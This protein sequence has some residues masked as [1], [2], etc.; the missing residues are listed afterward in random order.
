[1]VK[2]NWKNPDKGIWEF[3]NEDQHFTFS[4]VLC[5]VAIDRAIKYK[6]WPAIKALEEVLSEYLFSVEADLQVLEPI[7][8]ILAIFLQLLQMF[9]RFPC[10]IT[11]GSGDA[12]C[13]IDGTILAGILGGKLAP[14]GS[15]APDIALPVA[16][17]I[18]VESLPF[19][20]IE[21]EPYGGIGDNEVGGTDVIDTVDNEGQ[22]LIK[23]TF[24]GSI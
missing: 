15:I 12:E 8:T 1:M 13:G 23:K 19:I 17:S 7:I 24:S 9:F 6:N 3:R 16:Q 5:W 10:E 14:G 11:P 21:G 18:S 22:V 4:K 20:K 2:K